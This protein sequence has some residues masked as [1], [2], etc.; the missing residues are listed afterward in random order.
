MSAEQADPIDGDSLALERWKLQLKRYNGH[1]EVYQDCLANLYNAV[2]GQYI[3]ALK[4]RVKSNI[5]HAEV[6]CQNGIRLLWIMKQLTYSFEDKGK[7]S[8]TQCEVNECFYQM[9]QGEYKSSQGYHKFYKNHVMLMD[10][11][12][13][14]FTDDSLVGQIALSNGRTMATNED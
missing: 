14:A 10:E 13:A 8:D 9:K 1:T 6:S 4:D 11:V 12:R 7:L 2:M 5:K 3:S